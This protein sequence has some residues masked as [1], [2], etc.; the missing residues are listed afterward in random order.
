MFNS[1]STN[2]LKSK[3]PTLI[4]T[5]ITMD[6]A[7][8]TSNFNPKISLE[9]PLK[10]YERLMN[11][12]VESEDIDDDDVLQSNYQKISAAAR[13][14]LWELLFGS[15]SLT[16]EDQAKIAAFLN[17]LKEDACFNDPFTYNNWITGIRDELLKRQMLDFWR[18]HMVEKEL[19]PCWARDSDYFD[20]MEDPRPAAFYNYAGCVAP[21]GQVTGERRNSAIP[22]MPQ[23]TTE[24]RVDLDAD[25]EADISTDTPADDYENLMN[26]KVRADQ[27]VEDEII[28]RNFT[29]IAIAARDII[30]KLLF[31]KETVSEES[32]TKAGDLLYKLKAD[33]CFFD[34]WSYNKWISSVRDELLK[35]QMVDFW[36]EHIV[37]KELGPCWARDSDYFDDM[38]D[39]EPAEFYNCAG[40][41]AP[42]SKPES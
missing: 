29:K 36:R 10:D 1:R 38:D 6:S 24:D 41:V 34:P 19:G 33:A 35:R 26:T 15:D 23:S 25:F 42:F 18:E 5:R 2:L 17:K 7:V 40:C 4:H 21:F 14:A 37:A 16:K 39:K 9:T 30:W 32:Q 11:E 31:S 13:E 22:E 27:L 3:T 12:K 28:K 8:P 20:D